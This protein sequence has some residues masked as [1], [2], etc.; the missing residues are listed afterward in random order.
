LEGLFPPHPLSTFGHEFSEEDILIT[1]KLTRKALCKITGANINQVAYLRDMSLL[2]IERGTK[3]AGHPI[4]YKSEAI[5]V[6]LKHLGK[7][8][9][10]END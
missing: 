8:E 1:S 10:A 6:V 7:G 4:I 9:K 3:G 2:P 5:E